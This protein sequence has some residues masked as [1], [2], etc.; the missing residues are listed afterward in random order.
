M[1]KRATIILCITLSVLTGFSQIKINNNSKVIG[2]GVI[3]TNTEISNTSPNVDFSQVVLQLLGDN[4]QQISTSQPLKVS[5]LKVDQGGATTISGNIEVTGTLDLVN[6][7][8]RIDNASKL[9]YSGT[10][11]PEGNSNSFVLGYLYRNGGGRIVFP[12]G[13]AAGYLPAVVENNV[14]GTELGATAI[15][16]DPTLIAPEGVTDI[17]TGHY[18]EFSAPPNSPVSLSTNGLDSFLGDGSP[19]VLEADAKG[20]TAVSRSGAVSS[21]FV[22]SIDN[23]TQNIAAIGKTAEFRLVI[24]DMITP[25]T[26]DEKNDKLTI[27]NIEL[28]TENTVKLLD[29]WGVVAAEWRNY[30]NDIDYDFSKLSP[31][32]YVCIIEFSYPGESRKVLTKGIVTVLKSN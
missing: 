31:G 30:S 16:S 32:N 27:E 8:I 17:F 11:N 7:I 19:V 15:E 24:H 25:F 12:I 18:W 21:E 1:L 13:V 20:G 26:I 3:S 14:Q 22:T 9:L 5:T 23:L 2:S 6:G 4:D 10:D 29:R 28:V